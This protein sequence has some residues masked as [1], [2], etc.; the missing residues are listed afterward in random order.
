MEKPDEI[1][2]IEKPNLWKE[3]KNMSRKMKTIVCFLLLCFCVLVCISCNLVN[4]TKTFTDRM[5]TL[6][7]THLENLKQSI[8]SVRYEPSLDDEQKNRVYEKLLGYKR[9]H[10]SGRTKAAVKLLIDQTVTT[11]TSYQLRIRDA[12]QIHPKGNEN[13]KDEEDEN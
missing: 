6:S 10:L 8:D 2:T 11:I 7:D 1:P 12:R 4:P 5:Q 3:F 9:G 13:G